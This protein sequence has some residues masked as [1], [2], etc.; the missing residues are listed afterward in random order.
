MSSQCENI[1]IPILPHV[2]NLM[3]SMYGSE[4]IKAN[5]NNLP[6]KALQFIFMSFG[7][8]TRDKINGEKITL[9]IS[10][11]I[12]PYYYRFKNTFLLGCYFEKQFHAL[13]F[14]H[15]EAQRIA[16]IPTIA[17]IK[18]FYEMYHIDVEM[19]S[20]QAALEAYRRLKK[21]SALSNSL[22]QLLK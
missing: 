14:A 8:T 11:R 3:L 17:A 10:H 9:S 18:C 5:E 21:Q 22:H 15:I 20:Q 2:K 6:G 1:E 16:G 13:L 12:A 4:P 7:S 19:Y